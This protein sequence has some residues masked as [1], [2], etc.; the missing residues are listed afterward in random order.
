MQCLTDGR[1]RFS[2]FLATTFLSFRLMLA[3]INLAKR[4]LQ[5]AWKACSHSGVSCLVVSVKKSYY[6][7]KLIV[8]YPVSQ[9]SFPEG[10]SWSV[11]HGR[12]ALDRWVQSFRHLI[13]GITLELVLVV[14]G[15]W[16]WRS[17]SDKGSQ[18]IS[19]VSLD[20]L[21]ARALGDQPSFALCVAFHYLTQ[22]HC[23]TQIRSQS[24]W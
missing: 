7:A 16:P 3:S 19:S 23:E 20:S 11:Q 6:H 2:I 9:F 15:V 17:L 24:S 4:S 10:H 22:W 12:Q 8:L 14:H 21:L 5:E 18:P 13:I 1:P